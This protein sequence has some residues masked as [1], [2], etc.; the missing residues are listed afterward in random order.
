MEF[1]IRY[2]E[3]YEDLTDPN[4]GIDAIVLQTLFEA[5]SDGVHPL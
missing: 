4:S 1:Q 3:M 5:G 2:F